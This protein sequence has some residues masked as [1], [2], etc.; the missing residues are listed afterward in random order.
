MRI[1]VIDRNVGVSATIIA[2][3]HDAGAAEG[4]N[5]HFSKEFVAAKE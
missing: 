2:L 5:V 3:H 4:L 1:L